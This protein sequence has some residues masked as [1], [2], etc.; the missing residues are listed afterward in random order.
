MSDYRRYSVPGGTCFFTL[1]AYQ[2]RPRFAC[3][4]D[5][6]RLREAIAFVQREQPFR[7]LAAVV[8]PDHMHFVWTLPPGDSDYSHGLDE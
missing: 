1:A 7:F 3:P 6:Q 2:R 8:L 4:S 5:I